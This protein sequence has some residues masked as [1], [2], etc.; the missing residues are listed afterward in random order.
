M[1]DH[2][3]ST[4][5]DRPG[6]VPITAKRKSLWDSSTLIWAVPVIALAI[7]LFAAWRNYAD[8][9]PVIEVAFDEAAGIRGG[10]TQLRYRDITVGSV[11]EVSFSSDLNQVIAS[12]RID[13]ALAPYINED[14]QFW[15]VR[16]QVSAQ[17][18]SGLD[19]VLSGVY[20]QGSWDNQPG[21]LQTE[22]DGLE[23]A[24]LLSTGTDGRSFTL[25]SSEGLP[26]EGT[27]ILYKN[28]QVGVIGQSTVNADGTGVTAEAVI[29]EP[30]T[31]YVTSSTRFW[32]IS[33]FSF[34]LGASG[35]RLNF[36]SLASLISGGITFETIGSGGEALADGMTF[37][38]FPDE[39]AARDDFLVSGEGQTVDMI[40]IFDE[41]LAGLAT[42]SAVELGGLR[43]GE[44]SSINGIV[45]PERFGDSEVR[46]IAS[47]QLN[48]SRIGLGEDA[49]EQELYDYLETRIAEGMRARLTNASLFTGGL[50][51]DLAMLPN[52]EPAELDLDAEPLPQIPTGPSDV[53]DVGATA[54]G[55][56]QRV[57]DL[58]IEEVMQSVID[59]LDNAS[60]LIGSEDLQR[61]PRELTALLAAV[62]EV[63]ESDDVQGIPGQ[64]GDLFESLLETAQ[65][66]DNVTSDIEEQETI[67][68]LT[69]VI[70]G[71]GTTVDTLP[72]L[73]EDVRAVLAQAQEVPLDEL[74]DNLSSLL[75]SAESLVTEADA[76]LAG[77]DMQAVPA[78]LRGILASVRDITE[79]EEVQA[80]PERANAL[81]SRLQETAAS[82]NRVM[83]ELEAQDVVTQITAAVDDVAQAADGLPELVN[84]ARG[85]LD[86]AGEA[87]IDELADSAT[88]LL[89][90]AGD[91][92]DQDST[93][94]LPG[95]L[96]A[97]LA[98]LRAT[99]Q[100]LE[101]GGLVANAN[102]TLASARDAANAIADATSVLPQLARDLRRVADQAN[103]TLA[104]FAED[105]R[106]SRETRA[107]ITSVT[108]AAD[109]IEKLARTIERNP[110]SLLLGR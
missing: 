21:A 100:E 67:A 17:G 97:A 51:I 95:E 32:D 48:P 23:K 75:E 29:Y 83:T 37:D 71:A 79:N 16:P 109:A 91:V 1:A 18:V 89:N 77:E 68:K 63:A 27:P 40:M 58:P 70:E 10:E 28:V 20:I 103:T 82:L 62:R 84:Q 3:S 108:S 24:P 102:A 39:D 15:V 73:V 107:A 50:K 52:A 47:V 35:A 59:F 88:D 44:V 92:L 55:A 78:E 101:N 65:T 61:A 19:T 76:L 86:Q 81:L 69:G 85:I 66:L 8:Q 22:F 4:G 54:Q 12:I 98:S 57:S 49:G 74:A 38:L 36:T 99:L 46:L 64:V 53:T 105:S 34:S 33:G 110:N 96:N 56:L 87:R 14:A 11:E 60:G 13:K 31:E 9:G 7:A 106:F 90:A 93:R 104:D 25:R 72:A 45:D 30:H 43:V 94:A 42:G 6:D 80:L 41:N 2:P 5:G 26:G